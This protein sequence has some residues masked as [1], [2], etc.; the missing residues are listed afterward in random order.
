MAEIP[1]SVSDSKWFSI[2]FDETTDISHTT[3]TSLVFRYV[4]EWFAREDFVEFIDPHATAYKLDASISE[5][6]NGD[7]SML[8]LETDNSNDFVEQN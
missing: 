2:L 6:D 4:H 7:D 3:Q 5:S 1:K 8:L